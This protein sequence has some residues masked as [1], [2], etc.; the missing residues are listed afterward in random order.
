MKLIPTIAAGA[1]LAAAL[2]G[3][4][5]VGSAPEEV[6]GRPVAAPT[7]TVLPAPETTGAVHVPGPPGGPSDPACAELDEQRAA[8][9]EAGLPGI[10]VPTELMRCIAGAMG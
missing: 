1:A 8:A 5:I 9:R 10:T 7:N 6:A 3:I 2:I 4:T